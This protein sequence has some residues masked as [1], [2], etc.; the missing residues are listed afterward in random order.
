MCSVIFIPITSSAEYILVDPQQIEDMI[1]LGQESALNPTVISGLDIKGDYLYCTSQ[2]G[3]HAVNISDPTN[4]QF[5]VSGEWDSGGTKVQGVGHYENTLY[6]ANWSPGVGLRVLDIT[7]P[8]FPTLI[9]TKATATSTWTL[10]VFDGLMFIELSNS[11]DNMFGINIYDVAANPTNPP[12]GQLCRR[13]GAG[14]SQ[15]HQISKLHVF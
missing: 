6:A 7:N 2:W 4:M 1:L 12:P 14:Y 15:C 5:S 10:T 8:G 11:I 9:R 3:V 13:P